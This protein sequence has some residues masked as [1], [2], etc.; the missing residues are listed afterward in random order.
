MPR[1]I[2]PLSTSLPSTDSE[3]EP[4]LLEALAFAR[5]A[6]GDQRYGD[7]P[8]EV[9]LV[10]VV[11]IARW[12]GLSLTEQLAAALHDVVEDTS[13]TRAMLSARFGEEVANLVSAVSVQGRNRAEKLLASL[14]QLD[15]MPKAIDL[16]LCDRLGNIEA[17]IAKGKARLLAMYLAEAPRYGA[18]F[19]RAHPRLRQRLAQALKAAEG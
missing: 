2:E 19:A 14:A 8:Y 6:H 17:A 1:S 9:H 15:A 18:H 11:R 4:E 12:A 3:F 16:K 5:A 10:A 13:V 7:E